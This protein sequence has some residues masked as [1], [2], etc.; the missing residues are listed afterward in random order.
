MNLVAL[1]VHGLSAMAVFGDRIGVRLLMVVSYGNERSQSSINHRYRHPIFNATRH[2]RVG[3]LRHWNL[4]GDL[5]SDAH[6]RAG[7]CVCHSRRA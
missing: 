7:L 3:Y 5:A 2:T 1:V 4:A 6:N